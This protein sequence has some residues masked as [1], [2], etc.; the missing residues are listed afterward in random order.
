MRI[1][2]L[3]TALVMCDT[4]GWGAFK[5][6]YEGCCVINTGTLLRVDQGDGRGRYAGAW[7]EWDCGLREGREVIIGITDKEEKERV[8]EKKER[9]KKVVEKAGTDN[10]EKWGAPPDRP[11]TSKTTNAENPIP[12]T[13][14]NVEDSQMDDDL[15]FEAGFGEDNMVV[16]T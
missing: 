3:P 10:Y 9:K 16:D 5:V 4:S 8:K 13:Q 2:P 7:W 1:Y 12:E 11:T 14:E 6:T 15:G